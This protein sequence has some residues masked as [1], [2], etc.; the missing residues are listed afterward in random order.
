MRILLFGV[1]L[2]MYEHE[3]NGFNVGDRSVGNFFL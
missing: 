2:D 1:R 3:F